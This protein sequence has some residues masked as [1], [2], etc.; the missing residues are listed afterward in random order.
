MK[1]LLTLNR[2]FYKYRKRAILG[3][4]FVLAANYFGLLPAQLTRKALDF[5]TRHQ[6]TDLSDSMQT[7]TFYALAILGVVFIRGVLMFFMR[8]TIIVMSRHIE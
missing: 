2:Y 5:V 8:Q 7:I 3:I 4:L 1:D 6:H